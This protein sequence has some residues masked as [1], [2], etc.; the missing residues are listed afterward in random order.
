VRGE[1]LLFFSAVASFFRE[2][3][4]LQGGF[5]F[6]VF[7]VALIHSSKMKR[8]SIQPGGI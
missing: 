2:C 3:A 4:A 1:A 5:D 8:E 6:A 7:A